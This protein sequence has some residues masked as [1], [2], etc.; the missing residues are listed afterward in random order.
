MGRIIKEILLGICRIR[1]NRSIGP[2]GCGIREVLRRDGVMVRGRKK[3]S[4]I[5]FRGSIIMG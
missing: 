1:R 3:E 4:F 2:R 5:V